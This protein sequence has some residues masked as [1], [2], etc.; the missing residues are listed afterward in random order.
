MRPLFCLEVLNHFYSHT[1]YSDPD[2]ATIIQSLKR[3]N[4]DSIKVK[5][6]YVYFLI[7]EK[8]K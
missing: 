7:N 4:E 8:E 3:V 5:W 1:P 6:K 2:Q